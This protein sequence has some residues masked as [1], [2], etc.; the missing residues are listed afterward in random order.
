MTPR[1]QLLHVKPALPERLDKLRD[2]AFNIRW[3]WHPET[4]E[5]FQR[6]DRGLWESTG[7]NPVRML[8]T[9]S[10]DRLEWAATDPVFLAH[11]DRAYDGLQELLAR[12]AWF[13]RYHR[14]FEG[15][16]I[17]YFSAEF[18]LTECLPFYSGGLG[19]LAGDHLKS[20]SELGLPLVGV[21]LAY[22]V[23]YLAQYLNADGW[24][25]EA[26]HENDFYNMPLAL[27]TNAEGKPLR[28]EL[29]FPG[30]KVTL[31]IWRA[32][33]GRVP[34]YLLDSNLSENSP[35]DQRIT[36]QLYGGDKETRIQHEIVLG[37]GGV[38]ALRLLGIKPDVCH[39]N[40]GHAAFLAVERVRQIMAEYGVGFEEA[41]QILSASSIFT[42][43]TPVPAGFDI[44]DVHLMKKYF[45]VFAGE[46]GVPF[47]TLMDLGREKP[48]DGG[49]PFNM[50]LFA[51]RNSTYRN[52][53]S[54]L[55][56]KVSRKMW[57]SEW[58]DYPESEVP[59]DSITNGVH[60]RSWISVEMQNLLNRYL[61]PGWS[62]NPADT[63]AWKRLDQIPDEELW[64]THMASKERLVS[65]ARERVAL[66]LRNRGGSSVEIAEARRILSPN[67]LTIG[68]AR[69][70]AAYK[71]AAL[72]LRDRDRL[73]RIINSAERP[74]QFIFAG[75]AH[76]ADSAGKELIKQLAHF[77][78]DAE[79]RDS[80]SFIEN[81][82]M[83]VARYLVQGVDV[84]LN[85]P[86]RPLEASGTSG[87]KAAANGALNFSILDGWW[88]EGFDNEVGW[89]IGQ[90]EVYDDPEYQDEVEANALY[91]L[92]ERE[93]VPL[94]YRRDSSGLSQAWIAKMKTA[95]GRLA[96]VF[97]TNRMVSEYAERYYIPA[98]RRAGEFLKGDLARVKDLVAWEEFVGKHWGEVQVERVEQLDE[99]H[100]RVGTEVPVRV[101]VR[102]GA[103]K[104]DQ[105]SVELYHGQANV[106]RQ[107]PT[108]AVTPLE[109]ER[110]EDGSWWYR[111]MLPCRASGLYGYAV[112]V[113]P[114]HPDALVP[115][116][117][118]LISW[119]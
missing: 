70:F 103:L 76:P 13:Q 73:K 111:G 112:R 83:N 24:Q 75:K 23:G 7:H 85:T 44:F 55:H 16:K 5:L 20:A 52:A 28:L 32:Q 4:A 95:M 65:F 35:E 109:V 43:H 45:E 63:E 26:Y 6:L 42:T 37:I 96:P 91:N 94:Y 74:V 21:G 81:Y 106:E 72:I 51:V 29:P 14:D 117:S 78:R 71:R 68:F 17:A 49:Q 46:L 114:A 40:E 38:R 59:V 57:E 54:A 116:E 79:M 80:V 10:Q 118:T 3:V 50:A 77:A 34:L 102:L 31:Q 89:A 1:F 86:R 113:R 101:K 67:R 110:Q 30:R 36:Y 108:G 11:M 60:T 64:R 19:V 90:G 119:Y 2:L 22:K 66:Q 98:A 18:G 84:W 61:G 53:V 8:G 62:D 41:R 97:N 93:V 92:L 107:V 33:V 25:Q 56:G 39:I 69:R 48:G 27:E 104:P 88:D 47:E 115:N 100:L 58:K 82:D 9:I 15:I 105:V 12:S 87:M 99:N